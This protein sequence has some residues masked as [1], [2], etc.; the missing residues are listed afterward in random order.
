MR[1]AAAT[2]LIAGLVTAVSI[3]V[4]P[5]AAESEREAGIDEFLSRIPP[6][7]GEFEACLDVEPPQG[8]ILVR[9]IRQIVLTR[10]FW[11][12]R[13][14]GDAVSIIDDRLI[15][16]KHQT[17]RMRQMAASHLREIRVDR[18]KLEGHCEHAAIQVRDLLGALR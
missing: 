18:H 15:V 13:E 11:R 7:I 10:L 14:R 4:A 17:D 6:V 1:S 2:R 9:D 16:A 3:V 5:A 8:L 12:M